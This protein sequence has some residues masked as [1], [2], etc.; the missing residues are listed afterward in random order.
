MACVL[1]PSPSLACPPCAFMLM[2]AAMVLMTAG[3]WRGERTEPNDDQCRR[4]AQRRR[5]NEGAL[6]W[7]EESAE[8]N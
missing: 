1:F 7:R 6:E 2:D 8:W 4:E 5:S 3:R